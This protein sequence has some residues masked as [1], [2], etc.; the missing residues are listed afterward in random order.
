MQN[1]KAAKVTTGIGQLVRVNFKILRSWGWEE[2]LDGGLKVGFQWH[3]TFFGNQQ[4]RQD[5]DR[6]GGVGQAR[7]G[8][9]GFI[10]VNE[11]H[12]RLCLLVFY[13]ILVI[14]CCNFSL[15]AMG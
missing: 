15:Y 13:P 2:L 10:K 9:T 12:G 4:G 14:L 8:I 1:G 3:P 11:V 6:L 5:K 7:A